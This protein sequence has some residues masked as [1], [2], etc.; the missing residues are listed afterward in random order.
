MKLLPSFV[1]PS[2][3]PGEFENYGTNLSKNCHTSER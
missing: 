2:R 1:K 3:N